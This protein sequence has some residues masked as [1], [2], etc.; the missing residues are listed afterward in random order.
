VITNPRLLAPTQNGNADAITPATA[1]LQPAPSYALASSSA[2]AV[3]N[4]SDPSVKDEVIL[5]DPRI[6]EYLVAHQ[7]FSPSLYSTAR[8]VRNAPFIAESNK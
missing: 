7:R 5:R 8:Y 2:P 6:D 3:A 4:T 1:Q